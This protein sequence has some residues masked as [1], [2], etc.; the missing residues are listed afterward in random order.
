MLFNLILYNL[1]FNGLNLKEKDDEGML[2]H[3]S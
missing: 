2:N 3:I 1:T